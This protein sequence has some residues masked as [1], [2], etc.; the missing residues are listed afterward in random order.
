MWSPASYSLYGRCWLTNVCVLRVA[1]D[2]RM[3][4]LAS[5][6]STAA[7][8]WGSPEVREVCK[9]KSAELVCFKI[10][11]NMSRT[12][13]VANTIRDCQLLPLLQLVL[14]KCTEGACITTASAIRTQALRSATLIVHLFQARCMLKQFFCQHTCVC[15]IAVPQ[16]R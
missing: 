9:A 14:Q 5:A 13:A 2:P 1:P 10:L 7:V 11:Y 12:E 4:V 15:V 6:L 16:A 3:Q 8:N